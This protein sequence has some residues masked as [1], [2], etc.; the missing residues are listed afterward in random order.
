MMHTRTPALLFTLAVCSA[1]A[2]PS[3]EL[4]IPAGTEIQ[5]RLTKEVSSEKVSGQ[6]V[7]AVVIAPVLVNGSVT[8]GF[9]SELSGTTADAHP[10]QPGA[11][12]TEEKPATLRL[13]L[14]TIR[15]KDGP[16]KPISCVV[17]GID[18]ARESIDQSGLVTGIKASQTFSAL[19]DQGVT[20]LS[21]KYGEL[22]QMISGIKSASVK[23]ADPS[24][25][26]KPGVEFTVKL[27]K[28]LTWAPSA[29]PNTP[30]NIT[31]LDA[32]TALVI[33]QPYRTA[34][35]KPPSPSDMTN[36]M[37]IGT[38]EV[39]EA[40]FKEAGWFAS[41]PLGRAATTQTTQAIIE[42][43]GYSEAPM[44]VLTLNGN[45]PDMRFE[46]QNNT[47]ASRH[48]IRVW[49]ITQTFDGKPVFVAAATHDIKIYFS[50]TS[51][52][53]THGIDPDID[54]ER[55]KVLNDM[56]FTGRVQAT[57]LIGRPSIPKDISNATGDHL[58][59]DDKMAVL[60]FKTK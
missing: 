10:D 30:G 13:V 45:P 53:I 4:T 34:A 24:I 26:Y 18:N 50:K 8:I 48:H 37:F 1:F 22:G 51:K 25:D 54:K 11:N 60:E 21:S 7:S 59:T 42:N 33:Q 38:K 49:Q 58:K 27:T 28:A 23:E 15:G 16:S 29:S 5:L 6:P 41:D 57:A 43:R 17:E 9:G 19:A 36:L 35:L 56:L 20:K 3:G 46:K 44:S 47:F 31:P 40:A 2:A 12:G 39:V 14:T 55:S 52:S 32:L